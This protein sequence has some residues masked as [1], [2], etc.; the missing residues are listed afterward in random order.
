MFRRT[1][2]GLVPSIPV[3]TTGTIIL[4]SLL[5]L[6]LTGCTPGS[7]KTSSSSKP[8][9]TED[10]EGADQ[11]NQA[12]I[13]A[14]TVGISELEE[15]AHPIRYFPY[16]VKSGDMVGTIAKAFSLNQDSLISVNDIRNSRLLKIGQELLIPNQ[17]GLVHR[18][19]KG[20]SLMNVAEAH[21]LD[22]VT[23][24]RVNELPPDFEPE[25]GT[26]IFLPGARLSRTDLQE[27]NGDLF[28]W[29]VRGRL[30]SYYG[31]RNDPFTGRRQFHNGLD[32]AASWGTPLYTA[33][34]GT[35]VGTGFDPVSGNYIV[36]SHHS[37]YRSFYGHLDTIRVKTGQRLQAGQ[38]I[39]DIGS[40][41]LSTG[42]HVH[43]SVYK[44]GRTVNP[45]YLLR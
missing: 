15:P 31:Y 16:I 44:N 4:V 2:R 1:D 7:S 32:I 42:S 6:A 40:T 17:D 41:G 25:A 43:F 35:V 12:G 33:M 39:G 20:E 30:T 29:P 19:A 26:N 3:R 24:R 38:R 37:G 36:I 34:A 8:L 5:A 9:Q 11:D 27:I 14:P 21:E 13:G 10:V 23:I 28:S 18:M 22:I 45:L